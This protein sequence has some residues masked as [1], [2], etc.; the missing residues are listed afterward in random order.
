[1]LWQNITSQADSTE[2]KL[3][4]TEIILDLTETVKIFSCAIV[5]YRA[6]FSKNWQARN[7]VEFF[8]VIE[9]VNT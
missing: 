2:K 4:I 1:M 7:S 9:Q 5:F 6:F 3:L 8:I